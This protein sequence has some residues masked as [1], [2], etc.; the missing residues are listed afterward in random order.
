[1]RT[2]LMATLRQHDQG[3]VSVLT[4]CLGIKCLLT[5]Y[6]GQND[7]SDNIYRGAKTVYEYF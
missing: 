6:T 7:L 3:L 1:M 2:S 5:T 4:T